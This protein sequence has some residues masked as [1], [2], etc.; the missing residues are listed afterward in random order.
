MNFL[1]K[2]LKKAG[3]TKPEISI[4][5]YLLENGLSSPPQISK[6]SKILRANTYNVLSS[7]KAKGL[8]DNQLK[9]KRHIYFAKDP[10][11]IILSLEEKKNAINKV[12]PD[13]RALFK[14][15]KNKPVIKFYYGIEQIKQ[16]FEQIDNA[17]EILFVLPTNK[18]FEAYPGFFKQFRKKLV[19]K[20]IF[21]RDIVTQKSGVSIARNT[22]KIMKG[23]YEF[24]LFAQKYEDMPTSI[25][26][27]N[28]NIALVTFDEPIM[29]TVIT[30]KSLA[31]T[32]N[33]M[34][35]TM[36]AAGDDPT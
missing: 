20:Q 15:E 18:I 13:L 1:N 26:I 12:L 2:E 17:D 35:E 16:I 29:G 9:G 4:Y 25:R 24:R 19:E 8:I 3:L 10:S 33:V 27:W 11:S 34:F 31:K 30:S 23:Y 6:G 36:W 28:D 14:A 5:L 32:F 21:V 22:K 7:L